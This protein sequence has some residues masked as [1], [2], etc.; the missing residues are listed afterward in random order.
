MK[1]VNEKDISFRQGDSGPKYLFRGP[2]YEWG[3]IRLL[4]GQSLGPHYHEQVEETFFFFQ[5]NPLM[6]VEGGEHLVAEGDAFRLEA[7]ERHD[8]RNNTQG[9]IQ[10]LFIKAPWLPEDKVNC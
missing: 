1:R 3:L 5:G 4:P 2:L 10:L 8:I 6:V 7:K 9:P